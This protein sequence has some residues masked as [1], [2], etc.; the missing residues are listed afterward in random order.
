MLLPEVKSRT[1]GSRPR[2]RTQKNFEAKDQ[3][4]R[5][6]CSPK[7]K[8]LQK[9]FSGDLR[10]KSLKK[11][12]IR[13]KRSSKNF[14]QAISTSGKQKKVFANFPRGFWRF[15]T[16]FQR[17]KKLS[18]PRA[19][20]RAIFKDLRLWGQGLQNVSSRTSSRPRPSSRTPPLVIALSL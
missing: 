15:S 17:F 3:R 4:H 5:R 14:F 20:D 16:K 13:R 2:P 11:I 18:C 12:F 10:K 7:K 19:K 9:S 1:Q 8:H 6:K